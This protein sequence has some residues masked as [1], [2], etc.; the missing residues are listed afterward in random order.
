MDR[1]SGG[2]DAIASRTV[3]YSGKDLPNGKSAGYFHFAI[4]SRRMGEL[5][6]L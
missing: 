1:L 5:S 4:L 2:I 3:I 6:L